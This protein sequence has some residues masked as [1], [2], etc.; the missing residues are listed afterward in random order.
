M[1]L[2][3]Q[4]FAASNIDQLLEEAEEELMKRI[5]K[6]EQKGSGWMLHRL[7]TLDLHIYVF[8]TIKFSMEKSTRYRMI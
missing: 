1:Y 5:D 3:L 4:V 8:K 2:I 6:F 7:L